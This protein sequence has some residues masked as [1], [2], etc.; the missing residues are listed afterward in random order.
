MEKGFGGGSLCGCSYACELLVHSSNFYSFWNFTFDYGEYFFLEFFCGMEMD[1]FDFVFGV[2]L[3]WGLGEFYDDWFRVFFERY[4][5]ECTSGGLFSV[6][7]LDGNCGLGYF[8]WTCVLS[9]RRE[10]MGGS[11][12]GRKPTAKRDLL[13][14]QAFLDGIYGSCANNHP[15]FIVG[16]VVENFM[17][18]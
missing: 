5:V 8:F 16:G 1:S 4:D 11:S 15:D 7:S 18:I 14:R 17:K 9:K 2:F 3:A 12:S 10:K 13:S 6:I